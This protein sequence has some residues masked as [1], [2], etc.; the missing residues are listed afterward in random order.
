MEAILGLRRI[1]DILKP[2]D[3]L[4]EQKSSGLAEA[5]FETGRV[6]FVC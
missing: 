2:V 4:T 3:V 6:L 1:G 5:F